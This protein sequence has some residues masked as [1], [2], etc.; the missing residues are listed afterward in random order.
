MKQVYR[1]SDKYV[2][3]GSLYIFQGLSI[4]QKYGVLI[5]YHITNFS[6]SERE[7]ERLRK[8]HLIGG[9]YTC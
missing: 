5:V 9:R 3:V 2:F 6:D 7:R 8:P 1:Q 4:Q